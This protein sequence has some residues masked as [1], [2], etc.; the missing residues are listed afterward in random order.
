[1]AD[2]LWAGG[3][4]AYSDALGDRYECQLKE[5]RKRRDAANDAQREELDAQIETVEREY[6][7][8]LDAIDDSLF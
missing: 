5:L 7:S 8:K 4:E 1:M 2:S 6:Q 3:D